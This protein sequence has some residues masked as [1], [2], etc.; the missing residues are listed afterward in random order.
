MR[1]RCVCAPRVLFFY[2]YLRAVCLHVYAHLQCVHVCVLCTGVQR[3]RPCVRARA[4]FALGAYVRVQRVSPHMPPACVYT[5][6]ALC[7]CAR[8]CVQWAQIHTRVCHVCVPH[9]YVHLWLCTRTAAARTVCIGV[10]CVHRVQ[11]VCTCDVHT[12]T[13]TYTVNV[14]THVHV[15]CVRSV[16]PYV[17]A[18]ARGA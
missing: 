4:L 8:A 2:V 1:A 10:H 7:T 18:N 11:C 16:L 14:H 5:L 12:C 6:R 17:Y 3:S 9:P 13:R 15:S